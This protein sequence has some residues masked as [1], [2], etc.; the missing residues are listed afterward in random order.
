MTPKLQSIALYLGPLVATFVL[1]LMYLNG[2]AWPATITAAI[3][4]LCAIW[5]IFEPIPIPATS[6]IPIAVFPF[7]GVLTGAQVAS[8]YGHW[9]ILLLLGGFILSTA[10]EKS[11]THKRLALGMITLIGGNSERRLIL[12]FM[13]AS[14]G[15]S[16][17]I[18]NTA[19]TLMLL[20]VAIAIIQAAE[21]HYQDPKRLVTFS[22]ALILGLGYAASVGG[23][24]TPIGTPPNTL[25]MNVYA[26]SMGKDL[27][28]TDWMQWAIPVVILMIPVIWLW[29]TR[30]L[31]KQTDKSFALP[32]LGAWH[33]EEK[34]TL[35]V[36]VVTACLWIFRKEPFGGWSGALGLNTANDASIA[37]LAV[38]AMFIIPNGKVENNKTGRLLDWQSANK[39]PWGVLLLFA[40]GI[41]IAKAFT[42]TGLSTALGGSLAFLS[43]LPTLVTIVMICLIVTFLTELTSNTATT[44]LLM[45]VLAAAGQAANIDPALFMVPAAISASCAF[46][47]PVATGPNAVIFSSERLTVEQMVRN[48]FVLNLLGVLAI[49]SVIYFLIA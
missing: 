24:G 1:T 8:A 9:L 19:T 14:A 7:A 15:L 27:G 2:F 35:A 5:W 29:L 46:M 20:P 12:G 30:N 33:T 6:L 26:E 31:D 37:L 28:F 10:L 32:Q 3:T 13:I 22:T 44:A 23:M 48:G 47:L 45:P 41:T 25:F 11:G 18:S 42:S 21:N 40:G 4:T 43:Q 39:I 38:I 49:S 36:F 34:R 16:M 17:W